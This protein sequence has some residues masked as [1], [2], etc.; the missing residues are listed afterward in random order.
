MR[1]PN[2]KRLV[3]LVAM[4]MTLLIGTMPAVAQDGED[5]T[6]TILHTNDVH[7]RIDEFD[8]RGNTCDEEE[9]S[10]GECFGGVARRST[11]VEQIRSEAPNVIL[12]DA[13]DQFQGTLFYTQYKGGAAQEMMNTIGY[14]AMVIGNHE[15]DDGPGTLGSFIRGVNFPVLSANIDDSAEPELNGAIQDYTILDVNGRG[16]W[17]WLATPQKIQKFFPA[18]AP[19]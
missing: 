17:A 14:D 18:P 8:S 5:F 2:R 9:Q 13:G 7:A 12:L 10:A 15:F 19:T 6:L 4:L 16:K 3:V 1:G 11:M